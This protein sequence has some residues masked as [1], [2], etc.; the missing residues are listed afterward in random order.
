M[1]HAQADPVIVVAVVPPASEES[2][3]C[4]G[5]GTVSAEMGVVDG[6]SIPK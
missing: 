6:G 1:Y 4:V 2:I 5:P 3:K